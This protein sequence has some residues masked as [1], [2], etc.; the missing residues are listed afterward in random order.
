[1]SDLLPFISVIIPARNE[2]RFIENTIKILLKQNYPPEKMEV[3]VVDGMSDDKT[4]EII[5]RV[6]AADS[7]VLFFEN[8]QKLSSS[9]RNIGAKHAKG[10]IITYIDAHV[11]IES[12]DL[13][14][15]TAF[16]IKTHNLDVLSRPQFLDTPGLS[17]FQDAVALARKARAGHGLD[18]T[19]YMSED[20]FVEPYSSGATYTKKVFETIGYFD[21]A[22]DAAEDVEFNFRCGQAGFKSYT[23]MGLSVNYFPRGNL[24]GLFKQMM[25]YGIGRMRLFKKHHAG[26]A[27]GPFILG[28]AFIFFLALLATS[29]FITPLQLP[30]LIL[31]GL[32]FVVCIADC[33]S[34]DPKR[35]LRHIFRLVPI[36]ICIH[37]GLVFGLFKELFN[38]RNIFNRYAAISSNSA[39]KGKCIEKT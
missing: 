9:A 12:N 34:I 16:Y 17:R 35:T 23:S 28:L 22:F 11:H 3:I 19:I 39:S 1:M 31:T 2:E 24:K 32:Y 14:S 20:R 8:P 18:S 38:R 27:S 15:N 4:P 21:E 6:A 37:T 13:L 29:I 25:R 5:K 36:F 7:R 26:V 33:F 10:D 30:C